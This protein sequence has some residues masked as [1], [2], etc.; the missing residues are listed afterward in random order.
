MIKDFPFLQSNNLT[1]SKNYT[2]DL[3]SMIILAKKLRIKE[4]A[5][6]FLLSVAA[7]DL[8]SLKGSPR[9]C[10][11]ILVYHVFLNYFYFFPPNIH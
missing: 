11:N 4:R 2:S 1:T 6:A 10:S 8:I 9:K 7:Y 3:L 5:H